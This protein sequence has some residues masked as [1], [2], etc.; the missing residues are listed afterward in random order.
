[1]RKHQ[2]ICIVCA[3]FFLV[4]CGKTDA[5]TSSNGNSVGD[6]LAEQVAAEDAKQNTEEST[7]TTEEPAVDDTTSEQDAEDA[8][9]EEDMEGRTTPGVDYDLSV[10]NKNM[11]IGMVNQF[12]IYPEEYEGDVIRASGPFYS[13]EENGRIYTYVI[14]TDSLACCSQ[15][16][17]FVWDDGSHAYP[18]DYPAQDTEILVTGKF[19][20][21]YE[22]EGSN[23]RYCR[24]VDAT[25]EI[26]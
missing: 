19:N 24:L 18:G 5:R 10:M 23:F 12:F 8:T 20:A 15:V 17:E 16:L 7:D 21:Y 6:V 22:P 25:L 11:I 26:L 14:I 3:L 9:S 1:M 13:Y 2:I 4:G